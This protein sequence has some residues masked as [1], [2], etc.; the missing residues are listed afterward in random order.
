MDESFPGA[1]NAFRDAFN[2]SDPTPKLLELIHTHPDVPTITDLV[3]IYMEL[4]EQDPPQ[5]HKLTAA[6]VNLKNSKEI[7]VAGC[8][9][10][11]N[12][13]QIQIADSLRMELYELL[14]SSL[15]GT[16]DTAVTPCNEYL[17][18][19]LLS[20][21][22]MK[23]GLCD[24]P[25]FPAAVERDLDYQNTS[26]VVNTDEVSV[27][28]TCLQLCIS[29][30]YLCGPEGLD[31]GHVLSALEKIRK[32]DILRHANGRRLL[33]VSLLFDHTFT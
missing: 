33:E 12:P 14:G 17:I 13:I 21:T 3:V 15:A 1:E 2:L 26:G 32:A 25:A 11:G 27:L 8:D 29:G 9:R 22:V 30:S 28:G 4:V 20:A 23:F 18:A 5:I 6:L 10:L 16:E 31:D 19:S 24:S 7:T